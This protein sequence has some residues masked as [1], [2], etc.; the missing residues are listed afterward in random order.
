MSSSKTSRKGFVD[1][2]RVDEAMESLSKL[3]D[4]GVN[5]E[6]GTLDARARNGLFEA[7]GFVG[8]AFLSKGIRIKKS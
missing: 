6:A 4:V 3:V 5:G 2:G 1:F 7:N 8:D